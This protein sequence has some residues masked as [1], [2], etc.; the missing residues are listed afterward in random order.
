MMVMRYDGNGVIGI[1]MVMGKYIQISKKLR[2]TEDWLGCIITIKGW[3]FLI[4]YLR[5]DN[6]INVRL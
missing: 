6:Y 3:L 2:H 5:T 1:P 4:N